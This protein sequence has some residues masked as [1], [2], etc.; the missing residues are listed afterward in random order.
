MDKGDYMNGSLLSYLLSKMGHTIFSCW[1]KNFFKLYPYIHQTIIEVQ[2]KSMPL[3]SIFAT[4]KN[5]HSK[6]VFVTDLWKWTELIR[7]SIY[8]HYHVLI[9]VTNPNQ[10]VMIQSLRMAGNGQIKVPIIFLLVYAL[11]C[12]FIG[13]SLLWKVSF[14]VFLSDN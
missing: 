1:W 11:I 9:V 8:W 6:C 3:F 12:P 13:D 2:H 14:A 4:K 7:R 5:E 10:S